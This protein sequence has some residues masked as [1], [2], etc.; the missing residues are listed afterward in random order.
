MLSPR[1]SSSRCAHGPQMRP[2]VDRRGYIDMLRDE[3]PSKL[4]ELQQGAIAPVDLAQAAIGPGMAVFSR[5]ARVVEPNGK[6]RQ[7][8]RRRFR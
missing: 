7:R 4:R 3:L 6:A 8:P 1:P 5:F 2:I